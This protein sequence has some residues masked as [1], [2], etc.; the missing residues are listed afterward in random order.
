[1]NNKEWNISEEE[2]LKWSMALNFEDYSNEWLT[3]A[4]SLPSDVT[5]SSIYQSSL[6]SSG[7]IASLPKLKC[8][9]PNNYHASTFTNSTGLD[10]SIGTRSGSLVL[11]KIGKY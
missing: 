8:N 2:I 4:T 1:M 6:V 3:T 10:D 7:N 9:N 11:P 5:F